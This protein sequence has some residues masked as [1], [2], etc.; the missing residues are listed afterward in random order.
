MGSAS[1][2]PALKTSPRFIFFTDFDG[3]ITQ[4]DSND[5][6]TDELGFGAAL[7]RA[8]NAEVLAGRR[9][10]NDAFREM[11]H[12]VTLP[13]DQ[14]IEFL[15]A[16]VQ[17]DDGFREF[18]AWCRAENVPVVVLSGGMGPIIRAL[19]GRFLGEEGLAGLEIVSNGV[20]VAE[21]GQWEILF[22]DERCVLHFVFNPGYC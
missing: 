1:L 11:M 22:H 18:Y 6:M 9:A 3:T 10:F 21:D 5:L 12:S 17:L 8:G 7:R 15:L 4:Q 2:P 13:F 16:R 14:C 19:L 20:E